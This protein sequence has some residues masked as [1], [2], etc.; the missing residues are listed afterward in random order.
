MANDDRRGQHWWFSA[1][2]SLAALAIPIVIAVVGQRYTTALKEREIQ[3][4][5]VELALTILQARPDSATRNLRNWALRVVNTYSGVP[6]DSSVSA[7]LRQTVPLPS[8][9]PAL[10][11]PVGA[12]TS[13][14]SMQVHLRLADSV[15][16]S[17]YRLQTR[18]LIDTLPGIFHPGDTTFTIKYGGTIFVTASDP[19]SGAGPTKRV[20]CTREATCFIGFP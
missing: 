14:S 1:V 15:R 13:G 4:R 18:N 10:P 5:F 17:W 9:S 20:D 3:G 16:I 19:E 8:S 6:L 11:A 12:P 7:D 2:Q